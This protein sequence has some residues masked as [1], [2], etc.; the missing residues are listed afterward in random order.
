M[1]AML[2]MLPEPCPTIGG[3]AGRVHDRVEPAVL[4]HDGVDGGADRVLVGDVE[5]PVGCAGDVRG[6]DRGAFGPEALGAGGADAGG[7][8]GHERD[9]AVES[10][11]RVASA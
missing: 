9:G 1:L 8:T 11:H 2:M 3:H 10:S 4:G 7:P 6:D 5:D